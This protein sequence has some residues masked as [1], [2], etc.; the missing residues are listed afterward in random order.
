MVERFD[1]ACGSDNLLLVYRAHGGRWRRILLWDSGRYDQISGAFGD[2]FD[3]R[4]LKPARNGHPLLLVL[5]GTPWCTSVMSGFGMDVFELGAS[6]DRP[7]W[8]GSHDYRRDDDPSLTVRT[9][10]DGFEVR[11]PLQSF[12]R[13]GKVSRMGTMR[14]AVRGGGVHRVEPI[15]QNAI[16]SVEEWLGM[17][18]DEAREFADEQP[19]SLTWKM[20]DM[21]TWR[22]VKDA[23]IDRHWSTDYGAIR[24]CKGSP[25]HFQA[26]VGTS[27]G[28]GAKEEHGTTYYVQMSQVVNGY[29]MHAVTSQPDAS[30]TGADLMEKP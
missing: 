30:C 18:C 21:L 6:R 13:E 19:G 11:A 14:Y 17:P 29:R 7:F 20:Y 2:A 12:L 23:A 1:I 26:E 24:A 8:H 3:T 16:E 28:Y 4:I 15:A 9:T 10:A 27:R 5:H 25:K 22:G